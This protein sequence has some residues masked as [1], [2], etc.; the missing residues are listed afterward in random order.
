MKTFYFNTGVKPSNVVN[1]PYDYHQ[2]VGN[3]IMG[4]LVIPFDCEDVPEGAKFAFAC[5]NPELKGDNQIC[6]EIHNSNLVSK[7]AFFDLPRTN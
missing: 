4:T 2:R 7:Y 6:R 1:F 5:N 3:K